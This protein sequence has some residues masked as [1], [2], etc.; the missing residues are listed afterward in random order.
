ML[1]LSYFNNMGS[2]FKFDNSVDMMQKQ[3]N[4]QDTQSQINQRNAIAQ[5]DQASQKHL[6][7]AQTI[8]ADPAN[9]GADGRLTQSALTKGMGVHPTIFNDMQK[10]YNDWDEKKATNA[11]AQ[12][13]ANTEAA[14]VPI[15]AG[16]AQTAADEFNFKKQQAAAVQAQKDAEEKAGVPVPNSEVDVKD[17]QG[18]VVKATKY[19][20][21]Q[22]DGSYSDEF[23]T[24]APIA[25][26]P[27]TPVAGVDVPFSPEVQKQKID[28]AHAEKVDPEQV[29]TGQDADGKPQF[30]VINKA[31]G[32]QRPIAGITPKVGPSDAPPQLKDQVAGALQTQA[33]VDTIRALQKANPNVMG[34]VAGRVNEAG[35]IVGTNP[36]NTPKDNQDAAEL[37]GALS[38]LYANEVKSSSSGGRPNPA[39]VKRLANVSAK[40][41][42][43]PSILEGFLLAAEKNSNDAIDTGAIYRIPEAVAAQAKRSVNVQIPG[44]AP[45]KIPASALDQFMKDN[46]GATRLP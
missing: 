31:T 41:K 44:H 40:M 36:L 39:V 10:A 25:P 15:L 28:I 37:A 8:L 3:L 21:K 45:G 32:A 43:D 9:Y 12:Q 11:V 1:D 38:Y 22:D 46:P 4:L 6:Q 20:I 35:Q 42:D 23:R 26:P 16:T 5:K 34:A 7:A 33:K 30:F 27:K 18:N 14:K 24:S 17:G 13:N 29:V 2:P 19:R